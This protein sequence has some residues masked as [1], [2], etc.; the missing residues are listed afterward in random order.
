MVRKFGAAENPIPVP[1]KPPIGE[2]KIGLPDET[3]I[4]GCDDCN[5]LGEAKNEFPRGRSNKSH[6]TL[7]AGTERPNAKIDDGSMG[8]ADN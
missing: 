2:I 7:F 6:H 8:C 1:A 5:K 3:R 4:N